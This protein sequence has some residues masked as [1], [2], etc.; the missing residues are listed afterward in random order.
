M[1]HQN[2]VRAELSA[3]NGLLGRASVTKQLDGHG[4]NGQREGDRDRC[5]ARHGERQ[6][7]FSGTIYRAR[8][9]YARKVNVQEK[10]MKAELAFP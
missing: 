5:E 4:W 7:S 8:P 10:D 9:S 1:L 3:V 2:S 6:N